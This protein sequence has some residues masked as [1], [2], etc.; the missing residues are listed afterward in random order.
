MN[1]NIELGATTANERFYLGLIAVLSVA[2]PVVVA[3]LLYLPQTGKLGDLDVSFLPHFNAVL[4][5]AT[6]ICLVS[7]YYMMKKQQYNTH[8]AMMLA[9]F[10]LS[11]MFLVSYVV[12]H[13][14]APSTKFG[15]IDGNGIV[16]EI[17]KTA[18]GGMRMV[19]F[20]L[21]ILHIFLAA[22]IVPFVLTSI[23]FGVTKQFEKHKKVSRFTFPMWL[24]VAVSGVV[25]Y[26]M[27]SP[28]YH[29]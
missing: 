6:A 26:L 7:G 4:N 27:I 17:E 22:I 14:Q 5:S 23:Y 25:V 3:V 15:D 21:L 18:A 13:F 8:R 19:Y 20:V 24:F 16:S 9:A 10:A 1:K 29:H 28:Y 11:S 2:I 12:Y